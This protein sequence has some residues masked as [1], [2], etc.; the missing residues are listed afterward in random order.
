MK[1]RQ[2]SVRLAAVSRIGALGLVAELLL[3]ACGGST[4]AAGP[5]AWGAAPYAS[6]DYFELTQ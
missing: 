1:P 5:Q 3:A 6:F 2:M 4:A